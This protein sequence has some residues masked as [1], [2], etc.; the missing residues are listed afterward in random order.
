MASPE[1]SVPTAKPIQ[2]AYQEKEKHVAK[3]RD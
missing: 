1:M 3:D 2:S